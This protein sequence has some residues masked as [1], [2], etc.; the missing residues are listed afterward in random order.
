MLSVDCGGSIGEIDGADSGVRNSCDGVGECLIRLIS[1]A[2]DGVV[3]ASE[4]EGSDGRVLDEEDGS[5][6]S[7]GADG[8]VVDGLDVEGICGELVAT[9]AIGDDVV[10]LNVAVE[11]RVRSEAIFSVINLCDNSSSG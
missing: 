11:I 5:D 4:T 9:F 7:C 8:L 3:Q 1:A 10:E 2:T 6:V